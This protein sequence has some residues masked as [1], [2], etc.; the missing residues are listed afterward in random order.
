MLRIGNIFLATASAMVLSI[1][2][3][4]M[5]QAA[6][7][8]QNPTSEATSLRYPSRRHTYPIYRPF[9][10]E[11]GEFV[12]TQPE[13]DRADAQIGVGLYSMSV[14]GKTVNIDTHPGITIGGFKRSGI[15]REY[16]PDWL[17]ECTQEKSIFYPV[18]R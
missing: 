2:A 12:K 13:L 15:G 16:G 1:S 4:A 18:G 10:H 9:A 5:A 3:G 6:E 14:S 7:V 8:A 11:V 17:K